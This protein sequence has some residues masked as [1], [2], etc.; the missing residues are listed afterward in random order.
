MGWFIFIIPLILAVVAAALDIW[1]QINCSRDTHLPVDP[2]HAVITGLFTYIIAH[3]WGGIWG[4]ATGQLTGR[5]AE[6]ASTTIALLTGG[7]AGLGDQLPG[8][9]CG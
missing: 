9:A 4:A 5:A 8:G 7:S 6:G 3:Y 1:N 2:W